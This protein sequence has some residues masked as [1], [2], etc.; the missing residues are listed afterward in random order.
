MSHGL[1]V[2]IFSIS[3][4]ASGFHSNTIFN[5]LKVLVPFLACIVLGLSWVSLFVVESFLLKVV[6]F[7]SIAI[8]LRDTIV[9]IDIW[10]GVELCILSDKDVIVQILLTSFRKS[11]RPSKVLSC[12][13]SRAF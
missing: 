9:T 6:L 10:K 4:S 11:Y 2:I 12:N 13:F 3:T 7:A 5:F 1:R 8:I